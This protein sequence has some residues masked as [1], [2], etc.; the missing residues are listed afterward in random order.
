MV[1]LITV[2]VTAIA[3]LYDLTIYLFTLSFTNTV[4]IAVM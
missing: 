4:K 3:V 1:L 2:L